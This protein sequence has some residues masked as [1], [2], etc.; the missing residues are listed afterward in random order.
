MT[1]E[2][3][4]MHDRQAVTTSLQVAK[5]FNKNHHDVIRALENKIKYSAKLRSVSKDVCVKQLQRC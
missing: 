3:V 4:I 5:V 2:L 1:E